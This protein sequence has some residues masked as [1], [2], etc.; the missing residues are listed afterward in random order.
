MRPMNRMFME[1][2]VLEDAVE[3]CHQYFDALDT[4]PVSEEEDPLFRRR[5]WWLVRK[6]PL[7]AVRDHREGHRRPRAEPGREERLV[8]RGRRGHWLSSLSGIGG[9]VPWR[10]ARLFALL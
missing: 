4:H 5:V 3:R 10:I 2:E 6:D 7:V 9:T 1:R 8:Q